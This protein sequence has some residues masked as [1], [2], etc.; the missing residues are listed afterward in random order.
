MSSQTKR[1]VPAPVAAKPRS[2]RVPQA[3]SSSNENALSS[4]IIGTRWVTAAKVADAAP[5]TSWV[6]ESGVTTS[7]NSSSSPRSSRTSAS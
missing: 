1:I 4:D 6:G 2:A 5:P 7:G 3:T